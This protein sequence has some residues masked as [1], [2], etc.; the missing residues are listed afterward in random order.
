MTLDPYSQCPGGTGKK[1]KFCCSDLIHELDKLQRMEEGDQ[2]VAGLDYVTKLCAKYPD[3][4]CLL[5]SKAMLEMTL[6]KGAET[7][8]T[9]A[10]FIEKFPENPLA[11]VYSALAKAATPQPVQAM[12]PL[13]KALELCQHEVPELVYN[14]LGIVGRALFE[15]GEIPPAMALMSLQTDLSQGKDERVLR[16]FLAYQQVQSVPLLLRQP[17]TLVTAPEGAPWKYEFEMALKPAWQGTWQIAVRKFAALI[18]L[19]GGSSALWHNLAMLRSWLG[20]YA[21]ASEALRKLAALDV[22]L[23]DRVEAE[24]LAMLLDDLARRREDTVAAEPSPGDQLAVT[25]AVSNQDELSERLA[26]DRQ[27]K[28]VTVD[29]ETWHHMSAN[30]EEA[31]QIAPPP[32]AAYGMLDRPMPAASA[33][34]K[35]EQI[36]AVLGVVMLFGRQTDRPEKL[37]LMVARAN[38]EA[39]QAQLARLAGDALGKRQEEKLLERVPVDEFALSWQWQPPAGLVPTVSESLAK[40]ERRR[41]LLEVWPDLPLPDL[42]GKTLRQAAA[43]PALRERALAKVLI[44]ELAD[45]PEFNRD[46]YN[47]LRRRLDLPIAEPI[48]PG[49][50]DV[51]QV[52]VPRLGRVMVGKLDDAT[53]SKLF[54]RALLIGLRRTTA[55]YA[56]EIVRRPSLEN[57]NDTMM[58]RRTLVSYAPDSNAALAEIAAAREAAEKAHQSTA[59]WDLEEL[60]LRLILNDQQRAVALIRSLAARQNR[61]PD[62]AV[63]LMQLLQEFG[64]IGGPGSGASLPPA[65]EPSL[66]MG[67]GAAAAGSAPSRL[68][69]PGGEPASQAAGGASKP[70]IWTPGMG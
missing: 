42:Q 15:T 36:P 62:I 58:A 29:P 19:A 31:D 51:T 50:G 33:D 21:G 68:V 2:H 57:H 65:G 45:S 64:I 25:F 12:A 8:A 48:E 39:A 28:A 32:R 14:A 17:G 24:A 44:A 49:A 18:P 53:L 56:A 13:Q 61:E 70:V 38:I 59:P 54:R 67:G 52:A 43:D 26:A 27:L 35:A 16:Q 22:P 5:A 60:R 1:L 66:A 4:A 7:E 55:T 6:S 46:D 20:D 34:L 11:L 23:D 63:A 10:R 30:D 9:I 37:V 69:L 40:A 47:E 3:R 41:R